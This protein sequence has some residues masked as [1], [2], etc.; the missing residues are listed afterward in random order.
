[1]DPVL[2][3]QIAG[4]ILALFAALLLAREL[5]FI[6]AGWP[7]FVLPTSLVVL[8]LFLV[9][10]PIVFHG[11]DFG[12]EGR[13]HQL[14]GGLLLGV[15]VI[16][17]GRARGRLIHRLWGAPLPAGIILVGLMF[18][19]HA[20][21][22]GGDMQLQVVQHR[23]T[24]VTLMLAGLIQSLDNLKLTRNR[25]AATG[26]L[27][28]LFAVCIQLFLYSEGSLPTAPAAGGHMDH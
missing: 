5:G 8:G 10:D 1:M 26:W 27:V 4:A 2:I 25:W 23:I 17:L 18:T 21:H 16:E 11:G 19:L 9:L 28:L 15:A 14:Q 12:P 3:H 20:Q 22:G 24:G 6:R 13:Q 7:R